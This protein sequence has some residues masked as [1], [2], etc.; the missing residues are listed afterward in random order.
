[1]VG[2]TCWRL[3]PIANYASI[4]N[5]LETGFSQ[6]ELILSWGITS[7]YIGEGKRWD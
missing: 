4:F 6:T 3:T 5:S 2:K 7:G 1:M